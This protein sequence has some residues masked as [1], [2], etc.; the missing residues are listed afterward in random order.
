M[1]SSTEDPDA[2]E[3][4]SD[5]TPSMPPLVV[6]EEALVLEDTMAHLF[7][8]AFCR[9][10]A[11][12]P[13]WTC[14][15]VLCAAWAHW[16]KENEQLPVSLAN[17]EMIEEIEAANLPLSLIQLMDIQCTAGPIPT[18]YDPSRVDMQSLEVLTD[19]YKVLPTLLRLAQEADGL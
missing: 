14:E 3:C 6:T 18:Q 5:D 7:F 10:C 16:Y 11:Q 13:G 12:H 15:G 8:K 9:I 4:T 1:D 17:A 19:V 2:Y